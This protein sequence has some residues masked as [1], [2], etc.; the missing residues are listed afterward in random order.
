M[1]LRKL[2]ATAGYLGC[3]HAD[4]IKSKKIVNSVRK[5]HI[6]N[7][8]MQQESLKTNTWLYQ[9]CSGFSKKNIEKMNLV[10]DQHATIYCFHQN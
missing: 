5:N 1:C 9:M 10:C 7:V 2:S 3:W 6:Q 8:A 4:P